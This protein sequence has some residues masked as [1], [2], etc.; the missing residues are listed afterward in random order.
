MAKRKSKA[1]SKATKN[2]VSEEREKAERSTTQIQ[3]Y[4]PPDL[5][6]WLDTD[7]TAREGEIRLEMGPQR[8]LSRSAH[9]VSIIHN[10]RLAREAEP[11]PTDFRGFWSRV[12]DCVRGSQKRA[13]V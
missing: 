3:V 7:C 9:V 6:A 11:K 5:L 2:P 10:Y 12:M 4:L 1:A 13:R 8:T